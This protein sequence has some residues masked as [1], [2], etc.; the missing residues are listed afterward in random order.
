MKTKTKQKIFIAF[1]P[2]AQIIFYIVHLI[3]VRFLIDKKDC[4]CCVCVL[5]LLNIN[6][7]FNFDR[8][9]HL[10][11]RHRRRRPFFVW[12]IFKSETR[13]VQFG[14]VV[15]FQ[16]RKLWQILMLSTRM[17][18]LMRFW[19]KLLPCRLN[20]LLYAVRETWLCKWTFDW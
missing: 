1:F 17:T 19:R 4:C 18:L 2:Y 15:G 7:N 11:H 5:V 12:F 3:W 8:C 6:Y 16:S 9:H 10:H 14:F 20:R 13:S